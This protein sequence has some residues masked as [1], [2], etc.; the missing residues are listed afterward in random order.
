MEDIMAIELTKDNFKAEVLDS[1]IPVLV[2][3]WAPWCGPCKMMGPVVEELSTELAGK[4]KVC[5]VNVDDNED[6]AGNYDVMSIPSFF[7][8]KNG[9]VAASATGATSKENLIS[10]ING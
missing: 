3:F 5:K 6:L 10:L 9:E 4:V 7:V 8:F 2:D 1:T